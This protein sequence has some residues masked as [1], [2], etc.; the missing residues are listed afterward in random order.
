MHRNSFEP[1]RINILLTKI[2]LIVKNVTANTH[3][4]PL[5]KTGVKCE[6][7]KERLGAALEHDTAMRWK[8]VSFAS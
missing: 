6:A 7:S 1:I 2:K 4:N 3:Y 5:L 8:T